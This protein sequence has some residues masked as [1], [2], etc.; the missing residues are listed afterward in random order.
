MKKSFTMTVFILGALALPAGA[1]QWNM[2]YKSQQNTEFYMDSDSLSFPRQGIAK[3]WERIVNNNPESELMDITSLVEI[4]CVNRKRHII[5][6]RSN[7]RNNHSY[8]KENNEWTVIDS[9]EFND[10]RYYSWCRNI[11]ASK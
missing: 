4:D 10:A 11:V 8:V 2:Y 6:M 1:A 9:D 5:S 3:A 7:F